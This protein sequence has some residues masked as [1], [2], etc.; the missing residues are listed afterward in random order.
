M[1][2]PVRERSSFLVAVLSL[3]LLVPAASAFTVSPV[4]IHPPGEINPGDVV[5]LSCT[6]YVATGTAFPSYDDIELYTG[7][8]DPVWTYTVVV[9]G[10]EN[11]RAPDRGKRL[12]ISGFELS[13]EPR[14]EVLIQANLKARVPA[15]ALLGAEMSLVTIQ[16]LDARSNVLPNSVVKVNHLIGK[17]TPTPTPA[18][19]SLVITS[20]PPGAA[21]Y[22]DNAVKGITPVTLDGV[23]NGAHTFLLRLD[24][25]NDYSGDASVMA[26]QKN[27]SAVLVQKGATPT[28][29]PEGSGTPGI[30]GT[31][32]AGHTATTLPTPVPT[33][34]PTTGTLTVT[35]SP[36]GA[37]VYI[38]G[39]MKGITPATIPG[40][41][42]GTHS[43]TL[44][45][46]GYQDFKTTTEIVP[47][48]TSEFVTGLAKRKTVPGFSVAGALAA[49]G[50]IATLLALS[51]NKNE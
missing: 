31:P 8:D 34:K 42:G 50:L 22:L 16:E 4:N 13:Y 7:L 24:G 38:D 15:T 49:L 47:G 10:V 33:P 35:T 39:E 6:I 32:A 5:N 51:R 18:F 26:G 2:V 28:I 12:T 30:T 29:T 21:I 11:T 45:M 48:T 17:P 19:G 23:P 14:D 44:I 46:D 40:L 9:N 27:I 41:S 20:E 43:I 1:I 3:L 37:L 36:P 25:Y